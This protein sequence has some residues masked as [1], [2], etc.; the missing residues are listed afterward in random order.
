MHLL[1]ANVLP[2]ESLQLLLTFSL[3]FLGEHWQTGA[4]VV[5]YPAPEKKLLTRH[6]IIHGNPRVLYPS[7]GS[8]HGYVASKLMAVSCILQRCKCR[9]LEKKS[10]TNKI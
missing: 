3:N 9:I 2:L 6:R 1:A 10:T 7:I 4:G 8:V 5:V